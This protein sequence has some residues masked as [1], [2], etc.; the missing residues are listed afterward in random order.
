M[1]QSHPGSR[2]GHCG[3]QSVAPPV[4]LIKPRHLFLHSPEGCKFKAKVLLPR[5]AG[6][7]SACVCVLIPSPRDAGHPTP[8]CRFSHSEVWGSKDTTPQQA[9]SPHGPSATRGG[10]VSQVCWVSVAEKLRPRWLLLLV[11]P[12]P[13]SAETLVATWLSSGP[14]AFRCFIWC[15]W[16]QRMGTSK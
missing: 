2:Q 9:P 6:R 7:P 1:I 15:G 11:T 13:H 4:S 8:H 5:F 16:A 14:L 3:R 10:R 12:K